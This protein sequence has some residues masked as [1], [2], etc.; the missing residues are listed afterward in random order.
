MSLKE[1]IFDSNEE[2]KLFKHLNSMWKC[3]FNIY[4]QL[5][6]SKIVDIS[7]LKIEPKERNFLF[8][9]NVDYTIC[10]KND[11]PLMCIEFDGIGHGYSRFGKYVRSTDIET[12]PYRKNVFV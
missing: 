3:H 12:D 11:K 9:T 1:R 7:S 10:N 5:P 2:R 6:F 4:P 8:K